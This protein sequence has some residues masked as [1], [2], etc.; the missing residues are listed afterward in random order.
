MKLRS[1]L[2]AAAV[3]AAG[4]LIPSAAPTQ[5][6]AGASF[7]EESFT[8]EGHGTAAAD[9]TQASHVHQSETSKTLCITAFQGFP[10]GVIGTY[11]PGD[12]TA[13][14]EI[15]VVVKAL[16]ATGSRVTL[17]ECESKGTGAVACEAERNDVGEAFSLP[18]AVPQQIVGLE[19]TAHSHAR[20][21]VGTTP[22]GRFGCYSTEESEAALR[23]DMG[24]GSGEQPPAEEEPPAESTGGV[25]QYITSVPPDTYAPAVLPVS[26]SE[27]LTYA[28]LDV[29]TLGHDVVSLATRPDGSAPWCGNYAEGTCPL[30]WSELIQQNETTPV[31]GLADAVVGESYEYTCTI[32]DWMSGTLQVVA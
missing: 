19:C 30:I 24:V 32:H 17:T 23:S 3:L 8:M 6:H 2:A 12:A 25:S 5:A 9:G 20:V 10:V 27:P 7:C 28:N 13:P 14:S 21:K 31:R 16:T 1:V 4:A 18:E 29:N 22:L 15:H 11:D 26:K